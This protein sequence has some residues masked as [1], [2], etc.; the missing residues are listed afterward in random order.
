MSIGRTF[1]Y[2]VLLTFWIVPAS[3][4]CAATAPPLSHCVFHRVDDHFL[5]SC[6]ALFD[7]TPALTLMPAT[8]ITTGVWRE[9]IHPISVWAGDMTD[10][11]FPNAPIELEIYA[12]GWGVLRTEYGWFAVTQFASS[13]TLSFDLDA[14]HEVSPNALDQKIVREAAKILS[15]EGAWNRT[16]S[17]QC[18]ASATTYSIYC[19][20]EKAAID[21]TGGFNHRRPALES[22]RVIVEER[23]AT[24]NYHHR[25]MDYNNDPTTRLDDVQSLF[26]EALIRM[27]KM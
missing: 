20:M 27:E 19:A 25:L 5:G 17:R 1:E 21:V 12:G 3:V 11:G 15:T 22:V 7:Q 23:T 6:G 14:S 10:E 24:R 9:D 16:D 8:A 13:P 18:P 4:A 2:V 26:K